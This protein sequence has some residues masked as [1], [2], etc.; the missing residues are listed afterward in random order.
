M[1]SI[2]F[3]GVPEATVE[4]QRLFDEDVTDVGYVMNVSRL[5]AYQPDLMTGLFELMRH[6]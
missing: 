5:W 4:A 2:G 3:L 6:P 1:R